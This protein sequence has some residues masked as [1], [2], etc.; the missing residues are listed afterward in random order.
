MSWKVFECSGWGGGQTGGFPGLAFLINP[1]L[2]TRA[3]TQ[4]GGTR[5][6]PFPLG[7]SDPGPAAALAPPSAPQFAALHS[8]RCFQSAAETELPVPG[9]GAQPGEAGGCPSSGGG[10]GRSARLDPL[11]WKTRRGGLVRSAAPAW[12]CR[13]PLPGAPR[14]S[15]SSSP[16]ASPH[17]SLGGAR[18]S[19]RAALSARRSHPSAPAVAPGI[20]ASRP[21]ELEEAARPAR[22][23]SAGPTAPWRRGSASQ[24]PLWVVYMAL[25]WR[26]SAA[27]SE[28]S[29]LD[30]AQVLATQMR[31]L[32]AEELG[33]VTMQV[34]L[35]S[36]RFSSAPSLV[37]L[38]RVPPPLPRVR[39][40]LPGF[41]S[42]LKSFPSSFL[43]VFL[44]LYLFLVCLRYFGWVLAFLSM[45][46]ALLLAAAAFWRLNIL[47]ESRSISPPSRGEPLGVSL[48]VHTAWGTTLARSSLMLWGSGISRQQEF[49]FCDRLLLTS[50]QRRLLNPFVEEHR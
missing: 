2:R 24:R 32:A 21:A 17:R 40:P 3:C 43:P 15:A 27:D 38:L 22:R 31:K 44:S 42:F 12:R 28:F 10:S 7:D 34:T 39:V 14:R 29:I 16:L 19:L 5:H 30:E 13:P 8:H 26:L 18:E 23:S 25:F 37:S 11:L 41:L 45:S 4:L 49:V 50:D 20:M 33:V 35:P 6:L 36:P 46:T 9:A 48:Q 47:P 1:L